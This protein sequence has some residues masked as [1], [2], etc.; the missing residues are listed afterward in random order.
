MKKI[1]LF[2]VDG[3]I[4]SGKTS[5][6]NNTIITDS[7]ASKYKTLLVVCEQGEIEYDEDEL[8]KYNTAVR[9]ID[10]FEDFNNGSFEK[11]VEE[12]G[13]S[14]IIVEMNG[15]WDIK[16][17]SFPKTVNVIQSILFVDGSTFGPY[18][19]NMRQ[20]FTDLILR[21]Q[22]VCFTHVKGTEEL[23]K[24]QN[25][26]KLINK[27]ASY[28]IVD[29]NME[30]MDAFEEELPY[31]IKADVIMVEPDDFS[32]FYIDSYD[33]HDRYEGRVIDFTCQ[34][35]IS[36]DFT[37]GT[38]VGG[39]LI[40]NCCANDIQ[41]Y[42]FPIKNTL[43]YEAKMKEWLH[44]RGKISYEW[45]EQ[46]KEIEMFLTPISIEPAPPREEVLNLTQSK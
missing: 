21:S 46:Y 31:D 44:V 36:D 41:L 20:M 35:F 28:F 12:T 13:P 15:M 26:L 1:P 29:E 39:R 32:T 10:T 24:Y 9:Y 42:G 16:E 5:Y 3:M 40:M 22:V 34:A 23:A 18:F 7:K 6:I 14:R 25:V 8:K 43:G 4:D 17:I 19:S 38:F 33:H 45:S 37:D 11:A 27:D 2:F 30:I